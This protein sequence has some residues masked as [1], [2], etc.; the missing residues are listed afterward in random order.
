[1]D[2]PMREGREF[3]ASDR[4]G[5]PLVAVINQTMARRFWPGVDPIGRRV[6]IGA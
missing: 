2:I 1:M 5:T 4:E 3:S 6:K